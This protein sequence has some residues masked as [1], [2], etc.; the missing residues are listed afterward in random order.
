MRRLRLRNRPDPVEQS[1]CKGI[2]GNLAAAASHPSTDVRR[3][4]TIASNV[5]PARA[6]WCDRNSGKE[7]NAGGTTGTTTVTLHQG[8]RLARNAWLT[9]GRRVDCDTQL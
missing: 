7:G 5:E 8:R 2:R 3:A 1:G 9:L 6:V 4:F